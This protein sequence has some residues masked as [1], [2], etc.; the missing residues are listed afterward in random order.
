MLPMNF[1]SAVVAPGSGWRLAAQVN[2]VRG[3]VVER[4]AADGGS[5]VPEEDDVL[6]AAIEILRSREKPGQVLV[7][8]DRHV[9]LYERLPVA[10]HLA[11]VL[12]GERP[13]NLGFLLAGLRALRAC[14]AS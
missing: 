5:G 1:L 3:D 8:S 2:L 13:R 9:H 4:F 12:V 6:L 7:L 11:F 14:E 10:P